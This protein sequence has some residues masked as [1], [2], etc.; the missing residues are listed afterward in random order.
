VTAG[1]ILVG[2][3]EHQ[4][5]VIEKELWSPATALRGSKVSKLEEG[6]YVWPFEF[7]LPEEVEVLDQ[8]EKKT[9]SLPPSF[10]ERASPAYINYKITVFV[11]RGALGANQS[12][13]LS[14]AL[15]INR[16]IVRSLKTEFAYLPITRPDL[17]SPILQMAYQENFPLIGPDGELSKIW[18]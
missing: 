16:L 12:C 1:T 17:P 8:K 7:I 14:E 5:L 10:T 3:E 13:V 4:F 15:H 6:H 11:R 9:F 18:L 2:Q